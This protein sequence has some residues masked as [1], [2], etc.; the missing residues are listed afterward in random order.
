LDQYFDTSLCLNLC[1]IAETC[2]G[3]RT[4]HP[5]K[6]CSRQREEY[7]GPDG[8]FRRYNYTCGSSE[9]L[10]K[11]AQYRKEATSRANTGQKRPKSLEAREKI[12]KALTGKSLSLEHKDSL[13]RAWDRRRKE[14]FSM[15]E[16]IR[17]RISDTLKWI[18][19]E[20]RK[21]GNET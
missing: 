21:L 9:C 2:R 12:S 17:E 20:K 7:Y 14:G 19:Q 4:Y 16:E 15:P 8:K 3:K 11:Q 10:E 6:Y 13:K 5:C 1:P 18:N